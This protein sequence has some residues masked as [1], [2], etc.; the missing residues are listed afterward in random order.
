[1]RACRRGTPPPESP[2]HKGPKGEGEFY[3]VLRAG[4]VPQGGTFA[5]VTIEGA[6][7]T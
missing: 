3:F 7:T 4:S 5:G 2:S 6:K 1:M